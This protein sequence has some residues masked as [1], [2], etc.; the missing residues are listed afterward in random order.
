MFR[1]DCKHSIILVT[2]LSLLAFSSQAFAAWNTTQVTAEYGYYRNPFVWTDSVGYPLV[3]HQHD[4][5]TY[6]QWDLEMERFNGIDWDHSVVISGGRNGPPNF[7]VTDDNHI[8]LVHCE[9]SNIIYRT[10]DGENWSSEVITTDGWIESPDIVV[11]DNEI[12]IA[13][14]SNNDGKVTY[15]VRNAAGSWSLEVVETS[16][17]YYGCYGNL[18]LDSIGTPYISYVTGDGE[19]RLAVKQGDTWSVESVEASGVSYEGNLFIGP[20]DIVWLVY[21]LEEASESINLVATYKEPVS[22]RE[23]WITET[24]GSSSSISSYMAAAMCPDGQIQVA[25]LDWT[26]KKRSFLSQTR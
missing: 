20:D 8:H 26:S 22:T 9:A 15:A 16:S 14:A 4:I 23:G 5:S 25:N 6:S 12:H 13:W 2:L 18:A 19:L 24:V 11:R 3:I 1:I 10:Y 21:Y 17:I 7:V